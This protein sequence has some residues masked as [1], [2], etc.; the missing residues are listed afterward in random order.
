M[1]E[2][3][4]HPWFRGELIVMEADSHYYPYCCLKQWDRRGSLHV[5]WLASWARRQPMQDS[6][7][8]DKGVM[9]FC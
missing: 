3:N 5:I 9:P 2:T 8:R 1:F 6:I 4:G 7:K